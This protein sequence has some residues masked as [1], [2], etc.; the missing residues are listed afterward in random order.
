MLGRIAS[1]LRGHR[2]NDEGSVVIEAVFVLPLLFFAVLG[3]WVFFQAF[4]A[5]SI[6]VKAAYTVSDTLSRRGGEYVTSEYM[7]SIW[8]LHRFVTES[9]HDTD[10]RVSLIAWDPDDE[11]YFVCWSEARGGQSALTNG[12]LDSYVAADRIPGLPAGEALIM[13][14]TRVAHEPIFSAGGDLAMWFE[15]MIVTSPRFSAQLKWSSNGSDD[16][17]VSCF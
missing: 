9:N 3:T 12:G 10:L 13:V 1:R 8:N 16:G 7:D 14:E 15:D 11:E 17:A 4:R 2:R 5:Q 6:N